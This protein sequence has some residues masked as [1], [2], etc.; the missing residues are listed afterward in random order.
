MI[1]P[2][3]PNDTLALIALANATGLFQPG[4]ADALLGFD[5]GEDVP[6]VVGQGVPVAD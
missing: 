6:G 5:I 3:V 2:P 4:E 1:R